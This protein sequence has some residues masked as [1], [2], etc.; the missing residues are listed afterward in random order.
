[1]QITGTAEP[2][3]GK[4]QGRQAGSDRPAKTLARV[5]SKGTVMG[6]GR[7]GGGGNQWQLRIKC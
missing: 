7:T 1:M 2:L 4:G 5:Q 3:F 6:G